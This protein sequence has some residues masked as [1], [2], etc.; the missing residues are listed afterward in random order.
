M[1]IY[2][3]YIYDEIGQSFWGE[4]CSSKFIVDEVNKAKAEKATEIQLHINSPGGSVFEGFAIYNTLKS[5][6]I[7]TVAKIEGMCAS[8]ATLV[9]LAADTVEMGEY[10][11][12]MIHNPFT[13]V[14]GDASKMAQAAEMLTK[15]ESQLISA[16]IN[17]T[18]KTEEEIREMMAAETWFS[19]N[20][21]KDFGFADA[22][23]EP[24]KIAALIGH[25]NSKLDMKD[26]KTL[27]TQFDAVVA[28]L[29]A[30]I[31]EPKN[32]M[33]KLRDGDTVLHWE[34]EE[35]IEGSTKMF[36]DEAMTTPAPEGDHML[37]DGKMITLSADGVV[38]RVLEADNSAA[39]LE[40][41][42]AENEALKAQ[43]T[44]L[45]T[46]IETIK[47]SNTEAM[48]TLLAEVENLKTVAIGNPITIKPTAKVTPV[49]KPVSKTGDDKG[50]KFAGVAEYFKSI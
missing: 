36:T 8:I 33:M 22:V 31:A 10:S 27:A 16:Y 28:K 41:L 26:K 17:K 29:K 12:F 11:S 50:G 6:G 14:D 44:N 45:S 19:A 42:K 1:A 37:E 15:I 9:A 3:I 21:A 38:V 49:V 43:V 32:G 13:S 7:K 35:I 34:G 24:V 2:H 48:Q 23:T 47:N 4:G 5:S 20:E 25:K 39:E 30:F 40:A 46:E 18:G